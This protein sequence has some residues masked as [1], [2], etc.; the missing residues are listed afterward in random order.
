MDHLR[1]SGANAFPKRWSAFRSARHFPIYSDALAEIKP[2]HY[3]EVQLWVSRRNVGGIT[4][5]QVDAPNQKK[6]S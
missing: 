3:V 5:A 1:N 4:F 2:R 6:A